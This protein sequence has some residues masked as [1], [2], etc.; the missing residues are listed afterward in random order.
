MEVE[1]TNEFITK[2]ELAFGKGFLSPGGKEEVAKI[3]EGI[4]IAG[5]E[6]LD[7]GV[8]IGGPACLL[9]GNHGASKVTGI[10][11]EAPVLAQAKATVEAQ[12]LQG[13]VELRQVEPGT[14]PFDDKSFDVV[15]SKDSIIHIPDKLALFAD[16]FR[17]LK[18]GGWLAMSDWYCGNEPFT[19]EMTG[20][21]ESTGLSFAMKPVESD[22]ALLPKLGFIDTAILDRNQ[23]FS[24]F[25]QNLVANMEGRDHDH[26]V[27][28]LGEEAAAE[29]LNRAR[30]RSL[31]ATQGQLRPGHI[32]GQKPP[33]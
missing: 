12:G 18:P 5:R 31:I 27:A 6:V 16:V 30:I 28:A 22:G 24:E 2:L 4:D 25:S 1:Y 29:W 20:W 9:A 11:V 26:L 23:W 10:D 3:V 33:I 8:G 7:I 21:V 13:R 32:R 19:E 15:F 14:L 17:V